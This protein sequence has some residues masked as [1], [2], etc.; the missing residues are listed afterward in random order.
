MLCG[1]NMPEPIVSSGSDLHVY[2]HSDYSVT[3]SGFEIL[4][5]ERNSQNISNTYK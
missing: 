1:D 5:S 3:G 2:F 4:V